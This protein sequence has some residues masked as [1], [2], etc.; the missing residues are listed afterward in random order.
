MNFQSGKIRPNMNNTRE[1][2]DEYSNPQEE[3]LQVQRVEQVSRAKYR[4]K[5][6]SLEILYGT[7]LNKF[8]QRV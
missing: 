2:P 4:R 7:T 1:S 5:Y 3:F 8:A 6:D